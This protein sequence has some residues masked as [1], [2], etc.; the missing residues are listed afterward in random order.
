MPVVL[1]EPPSERCG[2]RLRNIKLK[3][4]ARGRV[5]PEMMSVIRMYRPETSH[6][7]VM[8]V[9]NDPKHSHILVLI[10]T[11]RRMDTDNVRLE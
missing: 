4:E 9:L 1:Q 11:R 7:M 2:L 10:S 6:V 5:T 8:E 3:P